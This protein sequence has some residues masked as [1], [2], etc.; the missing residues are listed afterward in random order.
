VELSEE[1]KAI[2]N[3][4]RTIVGIGAAASVG[5]VLIGAAT[6]YLLI[7]S[8]APPPVS[9]A[10]AIESAASPA[11]SG[12]DGVDTQSDADLVGEW[13]LVQG[14][15]SFVGYRVQEELAGLGA[16]TA[17]GR[18][19]T[20]SGTLTFDGGEIT[21]VEITADL[22]TLTSDKSMRDNALR[23]QALQTGN[24]PT[25]TFELMEPISVSEVPADGETVT[26]TVVGNLTLHGVTRQI[27]VEVQATMQSGSLVVVGSTEIEFADFN[28][29]QPS[30]ASVVSVEDHGT[31]EL[32][33]VFE[34]AA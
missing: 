17:V 33:L 14:T 10:A 28:I 25:A 20:V 5:L 3:I 9:L 12:A 8:D 16:A 2:M 19:Q 7:R 6:W 22:T 15:S 11:A 31:M 18:T 26:Q 21:G 27:E 13:G 1:R 24:Y 34:R 30:A 29:S 4:K 32:Q 23:T